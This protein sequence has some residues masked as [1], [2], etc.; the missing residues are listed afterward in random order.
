MTI[1]TWRIRGAFGWGIMGLALLAWTGP[2][3]AQVRTGGAGTGAS[4]SSGGF[5][6]GGLLGGSFSGGTSGGF[7]GGSFSGGSGSSSGGFSGFSGG[8]FSGFSGGS[9]SGSSGSFSGGS[10]SGGSFSGGTTGM[11]G[12]GRTTGGFGST[13]YQGVSNTNPFYQSYAEP[14]ASGM[15]SGNTRSTFGVPM[16]NLTTTTTGNLT[17]GGALGNTG[18]IS[19]VNFNPSPATYMTTP[20]VVGFGIPANSAA[21]APTRNLPPAVA[22]RLRGEVQQIITQSSAL[23]SKGDIRV[24][25]VGPA[26]VLQ[27]LVSDEHERRLA[28]GLIRLTPGVDQVVNQLRVRTELA[29]PRPVPPP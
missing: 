23:P 5:A 25:V 6:G 20:Y 2:A 7:S 22:S 21:V 1:M 29:T 24:S 13:T 19:A 15:G 26:V 16:F 17:G 8:S 12:G 14:L 9:F 4:T 27:G 11:T 18:G 28:E 3:S 10:F